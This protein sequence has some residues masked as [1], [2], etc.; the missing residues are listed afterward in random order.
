M[1]QFTSQELNQRTSWV[2]SKVDIER[3][4]VITKRGAPAYLITRIDSHA[5]GDRL[6]GLDLMAALADHGAEDVDFTRDT[7]PARDIDL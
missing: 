3:S 7:S 6:T 1:T 5:D 2:I 4:V